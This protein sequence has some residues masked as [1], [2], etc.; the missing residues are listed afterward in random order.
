MLLLLLF[1][2]S[3][4]PITRL[5]YTTQALYAVPPWNNGDTM[6]VT[7]LYITHLC[8]IG[9]HYTGARVLYD[10]LNFPK[11]PKRDSTEYL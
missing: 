7:S 9:L 1:F 4:G 2:F 11:F 6:I 5:L 3:G 10:T 8:R